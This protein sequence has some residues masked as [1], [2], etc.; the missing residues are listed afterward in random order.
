MLPGSINDI[1]G[2][3]VIRF[4]KEIVNYGQAEVLE[5]PFCSNMLWAFNS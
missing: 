3:L 5:E 4:Q 2:I 1:L